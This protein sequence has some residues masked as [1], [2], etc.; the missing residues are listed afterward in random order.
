MNENGIPGDWN[1]HAPLVLATKLC[2]GPDRH[3]VRFMLREEPN[4]PKD[5]GW[6][7]FSGLE[8]EGYNEN[9]DNFI[10]CPLNSFIELEPSIEPLI[11]SPVG[12]AWERPT[13]DNGWLKIED[14]EYG[15]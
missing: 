4:N 12:S 13:D 8:P 7:F 10:I 14:F 9:H 3:K 5:S 11:N 15:E 2:I 6:V 1:D